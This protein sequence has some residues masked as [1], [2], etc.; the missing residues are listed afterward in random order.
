MQELQQPG[1]GDGLRLEEMPAEVPGCGGKVAK[2]MVKRQESR[3]MYNTHYIGEKL[4]GLIDINYQV[5]FV[6]AQLTR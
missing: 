4:K 1:S 5:Q 2:A 6:A 3:M